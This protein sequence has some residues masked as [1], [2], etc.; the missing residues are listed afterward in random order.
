MTA[1]IRLNKYIASSGMCSRRA[2]DD[3]IEQGKVSVNGKIISELGF[4]ISEKDKVFIDGKLIHPKKHI[5]YRFYKPAGYITTSNDE[6]GKKA[7]CEEKGRKHSRGKAYQR[8]ENSEQ[9]R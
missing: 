8:H 1:K 4:L 3:L 6:K 9:N 7:L 5:Y 2:A